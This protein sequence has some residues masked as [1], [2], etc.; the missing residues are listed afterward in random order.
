MHANENETSNDVLNMP[1]NDKKKEEKNPGIWRVVFSF[2]ERTATIIVYAI[3]PTATTTTTVVVDVDKK[4]DENE[5]ITLLIVDD[6][7]TSSEKH[8]PFLIIRN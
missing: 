5:R 7:I 2:S 8:I 1:E 4:E 6:G 3:A